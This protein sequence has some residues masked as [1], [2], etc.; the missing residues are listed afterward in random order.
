[1]AVEMD[2]LEIKWCKGCKNFRPWSAFGTKGSATKCVRCRDR[3]K[4][5]YATQKKKANKHCVSDE[6]EEKKATTGEEALNHHG[7]C[8]LTIA[9]ADGLRNLMNAAR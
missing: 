8:G 7:Y 4:E 9:A 6:V 1:V 2:G 5:K 3:Q